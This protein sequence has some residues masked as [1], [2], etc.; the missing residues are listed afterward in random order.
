MT[1]HPVEA[2]STQIVVD[3]EVLGSIHDGSPPQR[4]FLDELPAYLAAEGVTA[5]LH[6][7]RA[8][9]ADLWAPIETLSVF[10]GNNVAA[11]LIG[12]V[13]WASMTGA[14]KWARERI[15]REP[16]GARV[17]TG[18]T[19]PDD[20][21]T[22][23]R[24]PT[25][26]VSIFGPNGELLRKVAINN[27][28]VNMLVGDPVENS[29][30]KRPS[31]HVE[32]LGRTDYMEP[33]QVALVEELP[34]FL[35]AEGLAADLYYREPGGLGPILESVAIFIAG[36]ATSGLIGDLST[37]AVRG[38]VAWARKRIRR[39]PPVAEGEAKP[40]VAVTIYGPTGEVLAR[41][42]VSD[43]EDDEGSPLVG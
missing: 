20:D 34:E 7:R 30:F 8:G 19:G 15:R 33:D 2:A 35:A 38:A 12:G 27:D 16:P 11:G 13:A 36:A 4:A 32:V 22:A 26:S 10:I 23:D 42:E 41:V 25:V 17:P 1:G 43:D 21:P 39:E 3:V 37:A 29:T 6:Y 9:G 24:R 28:E 14:I 31:V 18:A 5:R 40:I